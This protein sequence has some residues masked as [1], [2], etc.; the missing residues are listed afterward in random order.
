MVSRL[1][2]VTNLLYYIPFCHCRRPHYCTNQ[3]IIYILAGIFSLYHYIFNSL[4]FFLPLPR[5]SS[6][7]SSWVFIAP[8]SSRHT[9]LAQLGGFASFPCSAR[10]SRLFWKRFLLPIVSLA[11]S[12]VSQFP[13]PR[14][15]HIGGNALYGL[16]RLVWLSNL[17]YFGMC[18]IAKLP[19]IRLELLP[20]RL[21]A[22]CFSLN[23]PCG[24]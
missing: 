13:S 24:H 21:S 5:P 7:R 17:W 8:L 20:L 4:R 6:V 3:K 2:G 9:S 22:P 16:S 10:Y 19:H 1:T 14:Y 12:V 23:E 11:V 18:W 15:D